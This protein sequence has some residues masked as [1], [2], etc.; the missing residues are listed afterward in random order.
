MGRLTGA[1]FDRALASV[2][3]REWF[4]DHGRRYHR[5]RPAARG[6]PV[7][8]AILVH[9]DGRRFAWSVNGPAAFEL[10]ADEALC[11]IVWRSLVA[12]NFPLEETATTEAAAV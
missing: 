7:G 12:V 9:R 10:G 2:G 1:L 6:E 8:H 11:V 5:F 4:A 3:D